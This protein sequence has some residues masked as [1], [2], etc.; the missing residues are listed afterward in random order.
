MNTLFSPT[1]E[2][3]EAIA[4]SAR[5]TTDGDISDFECTENK[6]NELKSATD[7]VRALEFVEV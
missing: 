3:L 2:N 1:R 6:V 7:K 5:I 4:E